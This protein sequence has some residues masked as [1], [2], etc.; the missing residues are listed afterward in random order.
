MLMRE[1]ATTTYVC[2]SCGKTLVEDHG[3]LR[4]NEHGTFFAYGPQLLVRAPEP[5]QPSQSPALP[6]E[7][8]ELGDEDAR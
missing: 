5:E 6:W 3:A 1:K 4:C 2:P 7:F 8:E